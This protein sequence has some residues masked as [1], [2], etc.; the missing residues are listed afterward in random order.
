M[1]VDSCGRA[2]APAALEYLRD[3]GADPAQDVEFIVAT[4]WHDDHIRG[5]ARLV[6]VCRRARFCCASVLC[7]EEFLAAVHALEA[8]HVGTFGS[9][10]REMHGT[11]SRLRETDATPTLALANRRVFAND[12]C[13]IW[14]LS[15]ADGAFLNFLRE[16][17][18]LLPKVG[19]AE[20]R[21]PSLSPNDVA[22]VLWIAVGDFAV[23]LGA[24]LE[25][26]GWLAI[27]QSDERPTGTASAFKVRWSHHGSE[28]AHE[29]GVWERMLDPESVA[30]LTPWQRGGRV[31]PSRRDR[32]RI[33]SYTPNAYVT[34]TTDSTGQARR[35]SALV[36]RTI[37]QS[38]IKLRRTLTP[39][40]VRLRRG[41]ASGA[42]WEVELFGTA[43]HLSGMGACWSGMVAAAGVMGSTP[44]AVERPATT[45]RTAPS[46]CPC[47][48]RSAPRG[49]RAGAAW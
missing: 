45:G 27:L 12:S 37:R 15:P 14:S 46:A 38:G 19:R 44:A 30:V 36:E 13:Q 1:V 47:C 21:I 17:G 11:F 16:V 29:P 49:P 24:D 9:G 6:E 34:A 40:A 22:V 2:D 28:S 20:T 5:M 4:H 25:Q 33:L 7:H 31:L 42:Q 26:G 18:R 48:R 41:I 32:Q 3:L 43:C 10:L 35:R 39:D 8:R 23:L